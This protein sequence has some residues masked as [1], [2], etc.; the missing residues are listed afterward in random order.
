[1]YLFE[2]IAQCSVY[3]L[4]SD[5]LLAEA[6][7]CADGWNGI[8]AK[9]RHGLKKSCLFTASYVPIAIC[10]AVCYIGAMNN[11]LEQALDAVKRLPEDRQN[12]VAEAMLALAENETQA[13]FD[14][15]PTGEEPTEEQ[16]LALVPT[17]MPSALPSKAEVA[18]WNRL[19]DEEQLRRYRLALHHPDCDRLSDLTMDDIL[20]LAR[21]DAAHGAH[22]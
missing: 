2:I 6:A 20:A 13:L 10:G 8:A 14:V 18:A 1:M 3:V 5:R 9:L 21:Q 15:E 11:L 16:I 19:S 17:V 12:I 22:A 7:G 4:K